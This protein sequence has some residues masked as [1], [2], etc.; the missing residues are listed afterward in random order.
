MKQTHQPK[1]ERTKRPFDAPKITE[2]R[3]LDLGFCPISG[4]C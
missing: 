2:S 1:R 4:G 3:S